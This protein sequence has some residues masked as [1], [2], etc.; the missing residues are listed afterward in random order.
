MVRITYGVWRRKDQFETQLAVRPRKVIRPCWRRVRRH[1]P[2]A[3]FKADNNWLRVIFASPNMRI[4][5]G[6]A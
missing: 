3:Q 5:F 1:F 6:F 4:V 2:G